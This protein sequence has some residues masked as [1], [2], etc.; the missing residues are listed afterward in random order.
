MKRIDEAKTEIKDGKG[1]KSEVDGGI[2][3]DGQLTSKCT[4]GY[5]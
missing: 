1:V 4:F 2:R 5:M 3:F